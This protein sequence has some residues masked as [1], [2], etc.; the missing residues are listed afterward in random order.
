MKKLK[1]DGFLA[2]SGSNYEIP[3]HRVSTI[4]DRLEKVANGK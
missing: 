3:A 2:G 1:E 4:L